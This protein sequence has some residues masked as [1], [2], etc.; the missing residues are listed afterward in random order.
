MKLEFIYKTILL[1]FIATFCKA[2]CPTELEKYATGFDEINSSSFDFLNTELD[3]I[4]IVGYGEDTHGTAEFTQMA[5]NLMSYLNE[6]YN[7]KLFIIETGFGEGA[8]LNDYIHSKADSLNSILNNHNS[9]WRYN[10]EEFLKLMNDLRSYNKATT[11]SE[12]KIYIYGCEMQYV[13]SD[14]NR[15]K[16]YLKR[17]DSDY[18]VEG[19]EKHIWQEMNE[20]EKSDYSISY[21][22]LKSYFLQNAKDF[23]SKTSE[24]EFEMVYHHVEVLGQLVTVINQNVEQRKHDFRDIYMGENIQWIL[25]FHGKDSKALYWA[26]N[27]HIGDWVSNGI[28][29]VTGHQLKKMYG[30]SYFSIA[31]EFG[32]GTFKAFSLDWKMETFE[33]E[34]VDKDSFTFCLK[35]YGNPNTF[36]NIRKA[37]AN[38]D[39][40]RYLEQPLKLMGEAGAQFR[41]NKTLIVE[42]GKAFDAII[43]IDKTNEIN[44]IE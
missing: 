42:I 7:F 21:Y 10:T 28:V 22:R 26:H 43:Y 25:N 8:Y 3:N 23:K 39:L 24:T 35:S 12:D 33:F 27:A 5:G 44:F 13:I 19:F 37:K 34:E 38:L 9:T 40:K 14:I 41:N 4:K 6:R 11:D 16:E 17:V 36:L 15:I 30:N 32:T 18:A 29:D 20:G 1:L 31:T 2:Q